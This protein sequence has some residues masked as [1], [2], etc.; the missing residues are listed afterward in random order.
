MD[1]FLQI[2][3]HLYSRQ[4]FHLHEYCKIMRICIERD[5]NSTFSI[6]VINPRV[7]GWGEYESD[8]L[9]HPTC[10][11]P[12]YLRSIS[13]NLCAA[14]V[15]ATL[16]LLVPMAMRYD[17]HYIIFTNRRMIRQEFIC[18]PE[19]TPFHHLY[20]MYQA[21]PQYHIHDRE[22]CKSNRWLRMEKHL[23]KLF[24]VQLHYLACCSTKKVN[25]LFPDT[26]F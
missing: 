13:S 24:Q 19:T 7:H 5:E 15:R 11:N 21:P 22:S 12:G 4:C 6:T 8:H 23:Q 20:R 18:F 16:S 9:H 1:Y 3:R 10:M 26:F 14:F 17:T 2:K 25:R